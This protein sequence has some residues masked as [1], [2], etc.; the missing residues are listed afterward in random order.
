MLK[1]FEV[2]TYYNKYTDPQSTIAMPHTV[3]SKAPEI[4]IFI[5]DIIIIINTLEKM[6]LV[7]GFSSSVALMFNVESRLI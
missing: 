1:H 6:I 7:N 3:L 2:V 4:Y 5:Q